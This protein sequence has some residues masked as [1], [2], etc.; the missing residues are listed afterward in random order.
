MRVFLL[1]RIRKPCL[2][3]FVWAWLDGL[4]LGL[5][6]VK[7]QQFSGFFVVRHAVYPVWLYDF[8]LFV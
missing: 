2:M 3:Q 8:V 4:G 5:L 7:Y 1:G 6:Q